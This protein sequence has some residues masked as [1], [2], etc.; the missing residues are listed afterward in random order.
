MLEVLC[1]GPHRLLI[2]QRPVCVVCWIHIAEI[3]RGCIDQLAL[4]WGTCAN[5]VRFLQLIPTELQLGRSWRTPELMECGHC[6]APMRYGAGR[7]PR[8]NLSECPGRRVV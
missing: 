4:A 2:L 8:S 1:N 5:P 6:H 7:V 3:D